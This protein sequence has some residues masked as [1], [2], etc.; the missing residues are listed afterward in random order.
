MAS[1]TFTLNPQSVD[2]GT[3]NYCVLPSG[4]CYTPQN[5]NS[6]G[7]GAA[8][9]NITLDWTVNDSGLLTI[10][11]NSATGGLWCVCSNNGYNLDIDFSE[12]GNNWNNI[13]HSDANEWRSC[14]T[15][16]SGKSNEVTEIA[17]SLCNGLQPVV[18]V[19]SGY[20]RARMW[21]SA[22]CPTCGAGSGN[23]FPNAF[24][25]D[26]A[27]A[28]TAVPV[29]IDVSW[30][31][32]L[33]YNANGGSG[34]P[35]TATAKET[36]S[37][38]TFTIDNT[39]PTW[40][41]HRFEGWATSASATTPQYHGGDTISVSKDSP[42]VTLYA[43]WTEWYRVGDVRYNGIYK[44]THRSGGK[45]HLRKNG[46]WVEMRSIDA[47]STDPIDPPN[48]R[49]GGKWHNQYKIGSS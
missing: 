30:D 27:S 13:M 2:N 6:F 31:A 46:S 17:K 24:P 41:W 49:Y 5:A 10:S 33:Y 16:Y 14:D 40:E 47:G 42:T 18:L 48:R 3:V 32:T 26:A 7:R 36:G 29:H 39:I 43:V 15:C 28:A 9:K 22:A 34:A 38:H 11:F 12:D 8:S 37:S 21:T 19:K 25:N 23:S 44:T 45:C 4:T 20:I 35:A 1:G